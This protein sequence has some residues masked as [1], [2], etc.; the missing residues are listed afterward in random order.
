MLRLAYNTNGLVHH[1]WDQALDLLVEAGYQGVSLTVDHGWLNPESSQWRSEL[2]A[3]KSA[4]SA[5]RLAC[6]IE[7]GA[8]YLL[9]PRAKHEPTLVSADESGRTRRVQFLCRCLEAA[10]ELGSPAVSLWAGILRDHAAPEIAWSRLLSGLDVVLAA[11]ERLGVDVAFEPE[12]GMVV[13]SMADWAELVRRCSHPR[14]KLTLDLGHL[15]CTEELPYAR[16]ITE[17]RER[18]VNVHVEDIRRGVHEHLPFGEGDLD[19]A[20]LIAELQ[21]IDYP[22]LVSVELSRDSHRAVDCVRQSYAFLRRLET[23]TA[24]RK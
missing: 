12:P 23:E 19:L 10:A 21:Q 22:G 3:W 1:R 8:R 11:A 13:S 18:L 6:V 2:M 7:T 4:L 9:D 24:Q 14:L 15:H 20:P 17:W 16:F 5:R